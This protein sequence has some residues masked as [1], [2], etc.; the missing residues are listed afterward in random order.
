MQ[1]FISIMLL[2]AFVQGA[3]GAEAR[4]PLLTSPL[5]TLPP[6]QEVRMDELTLAPGATSPA[7]RHDAY[8]YVYVIEGEIDMQINDDEVRHLSAGQVFTETPDDVH[9]MMKNTSATETARFVSF[10][11][12]AQGAPIGTPVVR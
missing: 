4:A 1:K 2:A 6:N 12:K 11:I 10:V 8:V 9:T 5:P 3:A 7:H